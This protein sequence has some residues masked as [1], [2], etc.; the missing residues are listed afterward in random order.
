MLGIP[1]N[2]PVS[3]IL[4]FSDFNMEMYWSV[5]RL[6]VSNTAGSLLSLYISRSPH[7]VY[8]L[9]HKFQ[10]QLQSQ[11]TA[12]RA[13]SR[14]FTLKKFFCL[15][16]PKYPSGSCNEAS[17]AAFSERKF[18]RFLSPVYSH[19]PLADIAS[20]PQNSPRQ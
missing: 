11:P 20:F 1:T 14:S 6:A 16:E 12:S 19:T 2:V 7:R 17:T 13:L 4:T 18:L 8:F 5:A 3:H 15:Y 10:H 9:H